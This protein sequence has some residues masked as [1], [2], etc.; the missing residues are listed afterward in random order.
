M[1]SGQVASSTGRLPAAGLVHHALGHAVRAE[2]GDGARRDLG[3]LLDEDRALGL[4]AIDHEL[5]VHDLVPDVD[6]RAVFLERALDDFD[7]AHDAGAESA[8]L[9]KNDFHG[10]AAGTRVECDADSG[11][12]SAERLEHLRDDAVGVEPGLGVHRRRAVL[13][14]EHVRQ[15]HASAP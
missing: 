3:Q 9:R 14:D 11:D 13:I 12:V 7:G 6:R 10:R 2:D 1:T 5:V 8:R 4:E 15:H